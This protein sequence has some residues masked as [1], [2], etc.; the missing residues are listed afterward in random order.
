M[1]HKPTKAQKIMFREVANCLPNY[2]ESFIQREKIH[3]KDIESKNLTPKEGINRLSEYT[4]PHS[5]GKRFISSDRHYKRMINAFKKEGVEGY[6][7]YLLTFAKK[8]FRKIT[9]WERLLLKIGLN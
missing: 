6:R 7:Q 9:I 4:A 1:I 8:K 3:H 2:H 5:D